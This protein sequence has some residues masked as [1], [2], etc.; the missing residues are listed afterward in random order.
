MKQNP[1]RKIRIEKV[2]LNVG[3]GKD[4][5]LLNK[6]VKLLEQITGVPPIKTVTQKRIAAW[7][8]RPGLPIGCKTTLR[9]T[10]AQ[11]ILA[12]LLL[13]KENVLYESNFD[14]NGNISFGIHE[15][16]DIPEIKYDPEIGIMGLQ[17]CITLERRGYR[18]KRRKIMKRK[19]SSSHKVKREDAIEY[20]KDAFKIKIAEA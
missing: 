5:T 16:I 11:E 1:M 18:V 20:M 7:G 15:Y 19:I 12:K 10:R 8:I 14:D 4:Q 6:G 2:T 3:A 9:K 13:A 17:V